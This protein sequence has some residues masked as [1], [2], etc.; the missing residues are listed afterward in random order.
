MGDLSQHFSRREFDCHDGSM[1]HPE[2][3]LIECLEL[4]RSLLGDRPIH[5]VSGYRTP[6]WN[7]H[8]G[9]ARNS[10][11]LYNRAADI[12]RGLAHVDDAKRAGFTGIGVANGWVVHVDV[13]PGAVVVFPDA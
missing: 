11:H 9:G 13:R 12:P 8:V 6:A 5:I 10:Q 4:L 7:R 3:R 1:A 2:P